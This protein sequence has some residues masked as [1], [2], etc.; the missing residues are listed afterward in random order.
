MNICDCYTKLYNLYEKYKPQIDNY[1]LNSPIVIIEVDESMDCAR[2][3]MTYIEELKTNSSAANDEYNMLLNIL[4]KYKNELLV[5]ARLI[6]KKVEINK[7]KTLLA[8]DEF[9]KINYPDEYNASILLDVLP[10][11]P[12]NKVNIS[13]LGGK[14]KTSKITKKKITV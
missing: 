13:K 2:L 7:T 14:K 10:S 12:K 9:K 11:C 1:K 5:K 4:R 3:L 8:I 6:E